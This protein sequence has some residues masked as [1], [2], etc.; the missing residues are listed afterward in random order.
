MNELLLIL[1]GTMLVN[2]LVLTRF[3][4]LCPFLGV[5]GKLE[6]AVGMSLATIFVLTLAAAVSFLI[7]QYLLQPYALAYLR[8]ITFILVIAVIAKFAEMMVRKINPLLH[9]LLGIFLPLVVSNCAILGVVLLNVQESRSF[10]ESLFYGFGAA[11]GFSLV[12]VLF[13][14]IRERIA[15]A[16]V[17]RPFRGAAIA[18]ITAGMMSLAFMG[19]TGLIKT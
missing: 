10:L 7:D 16:D 9:Q 17:P 11:T 19:F 15:V 12:L 5:T 6:T 13:A 18:M 3:L 2:N 1:V 8:I 4:G 14:A